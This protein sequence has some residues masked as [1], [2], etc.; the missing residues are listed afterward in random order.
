MKSWVLVRWVNSSFP[1]V[2]PSPWLSPYSWWIV[3]EVGYSHWI[4][5]LQNRFGFFFFLCIRSEKGK[6][7]YFTNSF[8]QKRTTWKFQTL[9]SFSPLSCLSLPAS[10]LICR[11]TGSVR[12]ITSPQEI[13]VSCCSAEVSSLS[14]GKAVA[15]ALHTHFCLSASSKRRALVILL[16]E[17]HAF[18]VGD[19]ALNH[20]NS[21]TLP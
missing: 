5:L 20:Q 9:L 8:M 16:P 13:L 21:S 1:T 6:T 12:P 19:L 3:L 18:S 2:E 17:I 4:Q 14:K 7:T 10:Y 11:E 15:P